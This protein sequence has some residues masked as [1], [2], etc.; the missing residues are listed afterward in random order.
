MKHDPKRMRE[1]RD[2]KIRSAFTDLAPVWL[3]DEA[4]NPKE[5]G[6]LFDLIYFHPVHGWIKEHCKYDGVTDVLYPL[7]QTRQ[8]EDQVLQLQDKEPF[9]A[10]IGEAAVPDHP[11][12]RLS[13]L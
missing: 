8:S 5:D 3:L 6:L 2:S 4:Y 7:G 12:P 1:G 9:I 10:G 13:T 11:S